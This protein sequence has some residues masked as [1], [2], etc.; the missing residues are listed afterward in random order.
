MLDIL[1]SLNKIER[2]KREIVRFSCVA[3]TQ[4]TQCRELIEEAF[5]FEGI[6]QPSFVANRDENIKSHV[7]ES[8]VEIAL[9]E[10]TKSVDV[11][12]DM[13]RISHLLPN[14]ASVIVI[15]QEDA[16]ST[17]RNLK[18]MGF[19]YLFWPANKLEMVDFIKNVYRNREQENGLGKNRD[20]KKIAIWGCSGGVGTSLLAA[21]LA[22]NLARKHNSKCL[23]VDHDYYAGN[24]D[25]ILKLEGFEKRLVNISTIESDIDATYASSMTKKVTDLLSVLS[26]TSEE[27]SSFELKEYTRVLENLLG[28]QNNFIVSDLSKVGQTD[29]D[30]KYLIET[31]DTVVLV[32]TPAISSVR[33]L[34]KLSEHLSSQAPDLRQIMVLNHVQ[35]TKAT[36]LSRKDVVDFLRREIDIEIPFDAGILKHIINGGY[37]TDSRLAVAKPLALLTAS[38][39]GESVLE[40]KKTLANWF[41]RR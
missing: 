33:Q 7:R 1:E 6:P 9:V 18:Q 23:L 17:I 5:R 19:Y 39:L 25:I 40:P 13:H 32:F 26:L 2:K 4:S 12:A 8:E 34:K 3:F 11:T 29:V 20:A 15:G 21:E 24:I 30:Y 37:L 41:S 14:D 22:N 35:P 38:I 10:L 36:V 27:H 16:I 31:V 28:G